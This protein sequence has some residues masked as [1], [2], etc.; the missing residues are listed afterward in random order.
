MAENERGSCCVGTDVVLREEAESPKAR[1]EVQDG[2][3][4][5]TERSGQR[6]DGAWR[7]RGLEPAGSGPADDTVERDRTSVG[8]V[9]VERANQMIEGR[10]VAQPQ[11]DEATL[12][13]EGLEAG[14]AARELVDGLLHKSRALGGAVGG[15]A[16][17]RAKEVGP[18]IP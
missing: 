11:Q 13:R 12:E 7:G 8:D 6:G 17:P 2:R 15:T 14:D 10:K 16:D 5:R 9:G 3:R 1:G 4:E 18:N